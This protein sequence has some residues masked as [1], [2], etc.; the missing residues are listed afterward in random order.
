MYA[1]GK[2]DRQCM[3]I[4]GR[5]DVIVVDMPKDGGIAVAVCQLKG[6]VAH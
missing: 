4:G 1:A 6:D 3:K 2:F 5:S